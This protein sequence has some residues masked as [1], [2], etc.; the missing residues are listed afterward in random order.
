MAD[1][2][3][4][5]FS[6]D[7]EAKRQQKI[8]QQKAMADAYLHQLNTD[9]TLTDEGAQNIFSNYLDASGVKG[10]HKDTILG[11]S[12]YWI[13]MM[14]SGQQAP[15]SPDATAASPDQ[16]VTPPAVHLP[17]GSVDQ[18][19]STTV[20]GVE[21]G[22]MT[23][24]SP[25]PTQADYKAKAEGTITGA[26]Y[27]AMQD[28]IASG[29]IDVANATGNTAEGKISVAQAKATADATAKMNMADHNRAAGLQM[30]KDLGGQG[31]HFKMGI[32]KSGQPS[33]VPDTGQAIQGLYLGNEVPSATG[34]DGQPLDPNAAHHL[35]KYWD[36]K[37]VGFP[38]ENTN[39]MPFV[40]PDSK[41][42]VVRVYRDK[43]NGKEVQDA[44]GYTNR[45]PAYDPRIAPLTRSYTANVRLQG[46]DG[47]TVVQNVPMQSTSQRQV[48][49]TPNPA[50]GPQAPVVAPGQSQ[51]QA[52]PVQGAPAS[53]IS[54]LPLSPAAVAQGANPGMAT[55]TGGGPSMP[56]KP[57]AMPV[58]PPAQPTGSNSLPANLTTNL[59]GRTLGLAPLSQAQVVKGQ[60]QIGLLNT[61]IGRFK[62]MEQNSDLLDSPLF[63][64]KVHFETS[65]QGFATAAV[66]NAVSLTPREA[67]FIADFNKLSEEIFLS[68]G[69]LGAGSMPRS[70]KA[71]DIIELQKGAMSQNPEVIKRTWK[72]AENELRMVR[73][74]LVKQAQQFGYGDPSQ[75]GEPPATSAYGSAESL[76]D[77]KGAKVTPEVVKQALAMTGQDTAKA[78]AAVKAAH[79]D[80]NK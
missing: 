40:E 28:A 52:A 7:T 1:S 14:K 49:A 34:P 47:K 45:T 54:H 25:L 6:K 62:F 44:D 31:G 46:P 36:G 51:S 12:K 41:G 20:P 71:M 43:T 65:P 32:D 35:I 24:A 68:K 18:G 59:P 10:K 15:P 74:P 23:P 26:K 22:Q 8:D 16:T 29:K 60:Q 9:D 76:P 77:G 57:P 4:R 19:P 58:R 17:D 69:A 30:M 11:H 42:G 80:T 73:A 2:V 61:A 55:A 33:M 50:P 70:E 27:K 37:V 53:P 78:L 5:E 38:S 3:G 63:R 72:A 79:W 39:V 21:A 56:A 64:A 48:P 67:D 13:N 75:L 66:N